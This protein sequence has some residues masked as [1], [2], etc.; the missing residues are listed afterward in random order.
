[1]DFKLNSIS[2]SSSLNSCIECP[3]DGKVIKGNC[4][5]LKTEI[6]DTLSWNDAQKKCKNINGYLVNVDLDD[7]F[8]FWDSFSLS[9]NQFKQDYYVYIKLF[10]FI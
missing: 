6:N 7:W 8:E 1:M 9:F 2:S 3:T 4:Y 5:I 10:Y